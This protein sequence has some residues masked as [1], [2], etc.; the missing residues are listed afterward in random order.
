MI[1][2]SRV[3]GAV[4]ALSLLC[5][6]PVLAVTLPTTPTPTPVGGF[7]YKCNL[8]ISALC[9]ASPP[10]LD[11][12]NYSA[13]VDCS[14]LDPP[15][16]ETI[17]PYELDLISGK[18]VQSSEEITITIR[19]TYTAVWDTARLGCGVPG[20][21]ATPVPP[22]SMTDCRYTG[23]V[24]CYAKFVSVNDDCAGTYIIELQ[25]ISQCEDYEVI[26]G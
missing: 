23:M 4:C 14:A 21:T 24:L 1:W 3:V 17:R 19:S 7:N 13:A 20:P 9:T 25:Y 5:G 11:C 16:T 8:E 6:P 22:G 2:I 15:I 10:G 18:Y 12:C 26:I